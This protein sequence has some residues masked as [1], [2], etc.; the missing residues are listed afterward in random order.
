L[1]LFLAYCCYAVGEGIT[2][3]VEV[4][5]GLGMFVCLRQQIPSS[6]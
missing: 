4:I 3:G 2:A 6:I 5:V 1:L